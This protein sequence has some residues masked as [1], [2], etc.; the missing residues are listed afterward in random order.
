M[1]ERMSPS[2]SAEPSVKRRKG[3][4]A[5]WVLLPVIFV[6]VVVALIL[7]YR[8]FVLSSALAG[9]AELEATLDRTEPGWR[10]S[11]LVDACE[12]LE[13]SENSGL[14]VIKAATLM[15]EEHP[16]VVPPIVY[17]V[18]EPE[19]EFE[20]PPLEE[21]YQ[22]DIAA[23]PASKLVAELGARLNLVKPALE[24]ARK[25]ATVP[26]RGR[27]PV[28]WDERNPL[29][30]VR[31]D[32]IHVGR[33]STLLEADA[34]LRA[35]ENKP[36]AALSSF[37][38]L[39]NANRMF[40]CP[41]DLS[42]MCTQNRR[43]SQA[44]FLLERVLALTAPESSDLALTQSL[45]QQGVDE[46][47]R[48]ALA[49][50]RADRVGTVLLF[51]LSAELGME[52]TPLAEQGFVERLRLWLYIRPRLRVCE[53]IVLRE[54]MRLAEVAASP[55]PQQFVQLEE[56]HEEYEQALSS[57][58]WRKFAYFWLEMSVVGQ[59][60]HLETI[61]RFRVAIAALAAQRFRIST[62]RWPDSLRDLVPE[63]VREVPQDPFG[64]GAL[65]ARKIADGWVV[66][67]VFVP[68]D[69]ETDELEVTESA[70]GLVE[71]DIAVRLLD[72]P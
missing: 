48:L 47:P 7:G 21:F 69:S 11:E 3:R 2:V 16:F 6:A 28:D 22:L 9:I 65:Q 68:E 46:V 40:C 42:A 57:R 55:T 52:H 54:S 37:R 26:T 66:Y 36:A 1:G 4:P 63:Y 49:A 56:L 34:A 71:H 51:R 20:T 61:A 18:G 38:A 24:P 29:S 27:Y 19:P 13:E 23:E 59:L 53:E 10:W 43:L 45:L 70:E 50:H 39:I 44:V 15:G 35:C 25:L 17:F 14:L 62:G 58:N 41:V 31:E 33:V 67:S 60:Q 72:A 5:A 8:Y 30:S 32:L 64:D 12:P